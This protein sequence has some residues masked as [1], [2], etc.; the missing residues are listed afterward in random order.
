MIGFGNG[1]EDTQVKTALVLSGGSIKGAF[2]AGAIAYLLEQG[3]VPDAIYGTSVGSLN[4]G[5][6]AE[7]AGRAVRQGEEV[8]WK[9]LG[10]DLEKF[11]LTK[12]QSP[13]QVANKRGFIGLAAAL[14]RNRFDGLIDTSPLRK[15]VEQELDPDNLRS[16][17]VQFHACSINLTTGEATYAT[18][19]YAGILDYIIAST[20][21][22]IEM[23]V[24]LIGKSPYVDG[25]VREVAPLKRAIED[26]AD[27]IVCIVCQPE[28]LQ[29]ISFRPG[30]LIEFAFRLMEILTNELVNN[31][32]EQ[33]HQVNDWLEEYARSRTELVGSLAGAMP[34]QDAAAQVDKLLSGLR[35]KW[36]SIKIH[37]IRPKSEIVLDLLGFKPKDIEEVLKQGRH[38]AEAVMRSECAGEGTA[39]PEAEGK[40]DLAPDDDTH[41]T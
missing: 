8:D 31:D 9:G 14:V 36:R 13:A 17:P 11:W 41:A 7:R 35:G 21:I 24:T 20:A 27:E 30:N 22:P 16:S 5:F 4:G 18:P 37:V 33:F 39:S 1:K 28:K 32:L 6:L 19:D 34:E 38:A 10:Q 40:G 15:M 29:G 25:G 12:L 23:P 3:F 2:Q 26:Q